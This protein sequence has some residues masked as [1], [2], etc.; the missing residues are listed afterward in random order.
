VAAVNP[1]DR[2]HESDDLII[3]SAAHVVLDRVG[4]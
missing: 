3:A 4:G 2:N 1:I